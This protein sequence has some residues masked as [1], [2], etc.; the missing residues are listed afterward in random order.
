MKLPATDAPASNSTDDKKKA[1]VTHSQVEVTSANST[2]TKKNNATETAPKKA[3]SSGGHH[4]HTHGYHKSIRIGE[5]TKKV[6][7]AS[8]KKQ[9]FLT[10]A[11]AK[12]MLHAHAEVISQNETSTTKPATKVEELE[13]DAKDAD[14]VLRMMDADDEATNEDLVDQYQSLEAANKD[15]QESEDQEED[16]ADEPEHP[17]KEKTSIQ[18]FAQTSV[19]VKES[20]LT[21][22]EMYERLRDSAADDTDIAIDE[23]E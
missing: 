11:K 7:T 9:K 5:H 16:E 1:S 8:K 22:E 20:E 14:R 4:L 10:E 18:A 6:N 2:S 12:A 17:S 13:E 3:A 15:S 21:K 23:K 19:P